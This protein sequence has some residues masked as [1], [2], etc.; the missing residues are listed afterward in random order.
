[1]SNEIAALAKLS[2]QTKT[3][4]CKFPLYG[5]AYTATYTELPHTKTKKVWI[6]QSA[7]IKGHQLYIYYIALYKDR[8]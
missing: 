4:F 3:Q 5:I 1:M 8:S 2:N 6:L 7:F